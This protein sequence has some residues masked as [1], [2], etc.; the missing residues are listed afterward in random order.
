[1]ANWVWDKQARHLW[2][3][4]ACCVLTKKKMLLSLERSLS[5]MDSATILLSTSQGSAP[6][7]EIRKRLTRNVV[8]ADYSRGELFVKPVTD[9][10]ADR[11]T[12]R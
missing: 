8:F 10:E 12:D 5:R 11:E 9:R 1:M 7:Q 4:A 2:M 3:R 6:L